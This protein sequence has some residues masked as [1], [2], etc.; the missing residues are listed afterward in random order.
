MKLNRSRLKL[1]R[2][3]NFRVNGFAAGDYAAFKHPFMPNGEISINS[4]YYL[5]PQRAF[6]I[7][8]KL[9]LGICAYNPAYNPAYNLG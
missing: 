9:P 5:F 2:R 7:E 4:M 1:P 8:A 6:D 3:F